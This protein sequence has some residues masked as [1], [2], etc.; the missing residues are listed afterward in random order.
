METWQPFS[1]FITLSS[2]ISRNAN[3]QYG[4]SRSHMRN[5]LPIIIVSLVSTT[6]GQT[7]PDDPWRL[8]LHGEYWYGHVSGFT[9]TPSGGVAGT[10]SSRRPT[11]SELGIH[12]VSAY[13]LRLDVGW[14]DEE[15]YLGG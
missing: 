14:H 5:I 7:Q 10:S 9:Q 12:N 2:S 8:S 11:F 13:T 3:A 15:L 1:K 4:Q 6:F